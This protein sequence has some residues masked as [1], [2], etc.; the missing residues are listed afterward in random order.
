MS[1]HPKEYEIEA[2]VIEYHFV[3]IDADTEEEAIR[4][5]D[6]LGYDTHS[7]YRTEVEIDHIKV[8]KEEDNE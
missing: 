4:R 7:A 5:A 2:R 6:N 8:L 3:Q 1:E